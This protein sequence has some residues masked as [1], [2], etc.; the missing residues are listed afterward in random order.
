MENNSPGRCQAA[1]MEAAERY[2]QLAAAD[3]SLRRDYLKRA[4]LCEAIAKGEHA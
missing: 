1:D 4:E 2:R 3:P